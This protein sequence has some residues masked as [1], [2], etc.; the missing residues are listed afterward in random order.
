M[1]QSFKTSANRDAGPDRL[2]RL[3]EEMRKREATAFLIPHADE[4]QNEY[5]PERAERLAWLTGFTGSAGFAIATL[6]TCIVFLDGRYTLQAAEQI[7]PDAFSSESLIDNPPSKWIEENTGPADVI[8]YDPWLITQSQ[9]AAYEKAVAKSGA[10][11]LA[12]ENLIDCVWENQPEPPS[13]TVSLHP[14]ELAGKPAEEKLTEIQASIAASGADLTVLT[15]PASLAWAFNIRGQDVV[16]NPIPLGFAIV[17]ATGKPTLF[18][19]P[20]KISADV[21]SVLEK[22][23]ELEAPDKLEGRLSQASRNRKVLCDPARVPMAL[24][25]MIEENGGTV[26]SGRDP[27]ILPRAIKNATEIEGARAAH[28][29][30]GVAMSKFLYWLDNQVPEKTTE[31]DAA[32]KLE[33]IRQDNALA[34]GSE[35]KEIS[36][37]TISGHG[38]NGAIVHYR[39]TEE[40]DRTFTN[41]S[42]FLCD[43]G[44]QYEDGTTDITRTIAIGTPP[45]EAIRDFT[46]VLKGHIAIAIARFP[47]GTRGVELDPLARAPLWRH[48]KDYAHGTG[49]GVGSYMNVHEGPQSISKRG[50]E[51]LVP[52][53]IISNEPGYYVEGQYGIR[54]ENL[55]I[56][57]EAKTIEGGNTPVH[58]FE[59]ITLCPIDTRLVDATLLT[60]TE[61]EY[62]NAYHAQVWDAL[63]GFLQGEER[64]WLQQATK[65]I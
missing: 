35:L 26:I 45:E 14:V 39:V 46:L 57:E 43:S 52:G 32:R 51:P 21:K 34:M 60:R 33:E 58:A 38:P 4:H 24:I 64:K 61:L 56:V 62:L 53:M 44:G 50:M 15:D 47:E 12:T 17:P 28:I 7:H 10:K 41:D 18:M 8:A 23:S 49:H 25:E 31:I 3:R 6:K 22:V 30:D 16:H 37:D 5:L 65:A 42:L 13:G 2:V 20:E 48:G 54:I 29:R 59:T 63:N 27:V 40:T 19:E 55:V 36:F 1:F 11:L 9:M